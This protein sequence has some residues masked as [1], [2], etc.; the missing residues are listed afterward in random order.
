MFFTGVLEMVNTDLVDSKKTSG[1]MFY[2]G[3]LVVGILLM[4]IGT[5]K[6]TAEEIAFIGFIILTQLVFMF[7]GITKT[8]S[9]L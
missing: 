7:V 8:R 2:I 3:L 4:V 6:L 1:K 9:G 5:F